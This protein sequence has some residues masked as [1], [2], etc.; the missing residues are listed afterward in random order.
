[1]RLR[2]DRHDDADGVVRMTLG[3]SDD[4]D[5]T[6]EIDLMA[7]EQFQSAVEGW[8]S[9]GKP[10]LILD[11]SRV[12]YI[13]S[14]PFWSIVHAAE[15]AARRGGALVLVGLSDQLRRTVELTSAADLVLVRSSIDEARAAFLER[16]KHPAK[17]V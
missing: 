1:M 13:H 17:P 2:I 5:D 16:K 6:V 4:G 15:E 14:R 12:S 10:G 3:S 9:S 8:D 7:S 11:L